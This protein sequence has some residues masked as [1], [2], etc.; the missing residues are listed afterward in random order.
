MAKRK[1]LLTTPISIR[2]SSDDKA[3]LD[4]LGYSL[5]IPTLTVARVALRIGL[6]ALERDPTLLLKQPVKKRGG[7]RR[8]QKSAPAKG[9]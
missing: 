3:K 2:L 1:Q 4:A 8:G 9:E 5:P 6:E 7:R